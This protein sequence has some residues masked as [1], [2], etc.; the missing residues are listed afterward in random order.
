MSDER[1]MV[2]GTGRKQPVET[3]AAPLPVGAYSQAIRIGDLVFVSGQVGR[4]PATG[5]VGADVVTQTQQALANLFAVAA[6]AGAAPKDAVRIG[7]FLADMGLFQA[8]DATYESLVPEP[9]PARATVGA[10]LGD[11]LVELDGVFAIGSGG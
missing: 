6:A 1:T 4:D 7:A 10:D 9:R 8:F 3:H 5:A 11:W 2:E